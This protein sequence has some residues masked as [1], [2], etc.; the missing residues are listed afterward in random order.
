LSRISEVVQ[1]DLVQLYSNPR[2]TWIS[3]WIGGQTRF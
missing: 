2:W 1:Y 3:G